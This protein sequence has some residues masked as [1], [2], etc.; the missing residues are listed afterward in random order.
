MSRTPE[1][2]RSVSLP[3]IIFYGL[4]TMVGGGVYALIGKVAGESGYF[5]PLAFALAALIALIS[6]F[7][8]AEL[9]AK[10]P[11]SSGEAHYIQ[12]AFKQPWLTQI[13][14][15]AV[16]MM[17]VV[18]AAALTTA[19]AGFL[20]VYLTIP[21]FILI[22]LTVLFLAAFAIWGIKQ[23]VWFV[24][25]AT[26][27]SVGGLVFVIFTADTAWSV[28]PAR[29][30]T[31][32]PSSEALNAVFWLSVVNGAFLAFYA[33]VGFEDMVNIAEEVKDVKRT[34]PI[35]IIVCIFLTFLLYVLVSTV[36]VLSATPEALSQ[37]Q[38]PLALIV[39]NNNSFMPPWL[40][41]SI[42]LM[43]VIN[44]ALVQII[45]ASRVIYGMAK[46]DRAPKI[47]EN[48]SEKTQTPIQAT[49]L[50]AAI[51]LILALA[52]NLTLL[53]KITSTLIFFVFTLV[54]AALIKIKLTEKFKPIN[55]PSYPIIFPIL[56]LLSAFSMMCVGIYAQ[57]FSGS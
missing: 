39:K 3:F 53:A 57:F 24:S 51:V 20:G 31:L 50:S 14:A 47:F 19:A 30:P 43:A 11:Y 27:V 44:S 4:G 18:S 49:L 21:K 22:A 13:V 2:K 42:S 26:W 45:M 28:L 35:A 23:S 36:S 1:L 17:G 29:W 5:A 10:Y 41:T 38:S 15:W 12:N 46:L 55:L 32:I 16:V 48:I 9:V 25:L 33:F 8:Y 52:F 6:A 40:M 7:S 56:G 34:M 54:N 37:S